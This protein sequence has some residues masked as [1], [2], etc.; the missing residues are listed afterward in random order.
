M[1]KAVRISSIIIG[2]IEVFLLVIFAYFAFGLLFDTSSQDTLEALIASGMDAQEAQAIIDQGYWVFW[3]L[4][5]YTLIGVAANFMIFGIS[6]KKAKPRKTT[7]IPIGIFGFLFGAQVAGAL[8][9]VWAY[10]PPEENN[11]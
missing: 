4:T 5:G 10:M 1:R 7:L 11:G 3:G 2:I 6:L 8:A 9:F